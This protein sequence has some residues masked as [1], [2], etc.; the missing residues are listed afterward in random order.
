MVKGFKEFLKVEAEKETAAM[1]QMNLV[2]QKYEPFLDDIGAKFSSREAYGTVEFHAR[3]DHHNT[4]Y[5]T[6]D[7]ALQKHFPII[8]AAVSKV[9]KIGNIDYNVKT[10]SGAFFYLYLKVTSTPDVTMMM[11][12]FAITKT[13]KVF[14]L[15]LTTSH[16]LAH[17]SV[18]YGTMSRYGGYL[19]SSKK[20]TK[21][22]NF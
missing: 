14:D 15:K 3:V 1:K 9:A 12:R 10:W 13:E 4:D 11:D 8:H 21:V 6:V 19:D 20:S 16:D 5:H 7:L 18:M 17:G 22:L 2:A